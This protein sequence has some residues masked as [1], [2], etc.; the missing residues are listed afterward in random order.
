MATLTIRG[1]TFTPRSPSVSI[2]G[3]V[4]AEQV[5]FVVDESWRGLELQAQ[6]SNTSTDR[7]PI[8]VALDETMTCYVPA[9]ATAQPGKVYVAL[10]GYDDG[11]QIKL[12]DLLHYS[13]AKTGADPNGGVPPEEQTPGY[14]NQ[15]TQILNETKAVA[16]SVR[17]D[18]DQGKFNGPEGP[19]GKSPIIQDNN[20]WI[21]DV[22]AQEYRDTGI[23]ASGGGVSSYNDL[24]DR[25]K[26]GGVLLE[27]NKTAQDLGLQPKGEYATTSSKL[28]NPYSLTFAGAV[29]AAYDG[30]QAVTVTIPTIAGPPGATPDIQIGTVETLDPGSDAMATITGTPE[31]PRLNL[32]IPRGQNGK[33]PAKGIDYFTEEDIQD[34]ARRAAE[35]VEVKKATIPQNPQIDYTVPSDSQIVYFDEISGKKLSDYGYTY[36][37]IMVENVPKSPA[38]SNNFFA[39]VNESEMGETPQI[40]AGNSFICT[41]AKRFFAGWIDTETGQAISV[42]PLASSETISTAKA[43]IFSSFF[44]EMISSICF[45][46]AT[47]ACPIYSGTNIKVW[48]S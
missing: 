11:V 15:I 48:F 2:V 43:Q 18:A 40:E 20:W 10:A 27:G 30:S 33:T 45:K 35:L 39:F 38:I 7:E 16:Q 22:E 25:P 19:P 41:G 23:A 44:G 32:G 46:V 42:A 9:E 8:P 47:D 12:T 6:F 31:E 36:A 3:Q 24:S 13:N 37:R 4:N 14:L 26:I 17:D 29:E 5:T 34:V 1:N 21:W 28:A